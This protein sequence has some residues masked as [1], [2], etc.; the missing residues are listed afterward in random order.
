MNVIAFSR[1]SFIE[2][3]NGEIVKV[4]WFCD[5]QSDDNNISSI[6]VY[7]SPNNVVLDDESWWVM[8]TYV[9]IVTRTNFVFKSVYTLDEKLYKW[10]TY[11]INCIKTSLERINRE[12]VLDFVKVNIRPIDTTSL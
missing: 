1:K 11:A 9:E 10:D 2:N 8:H 6:N 3:Q 7:Y 12:Y 4:G 5:V